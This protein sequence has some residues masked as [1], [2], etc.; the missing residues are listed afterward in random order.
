MKTIYF[1]V[2]NIDDNG[3]KLTLKPDFLPDD[4]Y[5]TNIE[6][7][8]KNDEYKGMVVK[9][10]KSGVLIA[11]FGGVKAWLKSCSEPTKIYGDMF[12]PGEIVN[13]LLNM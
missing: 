8:K 5:L 2:W 9:T 11:F 12:Y 13:I 4:K 10:Y 7:A 3:V 6:M 1:R